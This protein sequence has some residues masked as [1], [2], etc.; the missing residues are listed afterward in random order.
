MINEGFFLWMENLPLTQ[1]FAES[2]LVYPVV[3]G[4]HVIAL[5]LSV[6]ILALV[7]LRMAGVLLKKHDWRN[8]VSQLRPWFVV[9]FVL[10]LA[11]GLLLFMPMASYFA[12][13]RVF[14]V[15]MGLILLAGVN[16]FAFE[17]FSRREQR[18]LELQQGGAAVVQPTLSLRLFAVF[19]LV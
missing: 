7:D 9:S 2:M 6:G 10:I 14:Q 18:A 12:E 4:V 19:S 15:K 8:F 11:T 1:A 17:V 13:S 5:A 3:L 16:A